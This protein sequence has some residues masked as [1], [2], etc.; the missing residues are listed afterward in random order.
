[1]T[2]RANRTP[3]TEL[4]EAMTASL[5]AAHW[6]VTLVGRLG[7]QEAPAVHDP[8]ETR[9]SHAEFALRQRV[10]WALGQMAQQLA[11]PARLRSQRQPDGIPNA[12]LTQH[13]LLMDG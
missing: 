5:D 10:T 4:N 8:F 6:A 7:A 9:R 2:R 3:L 1:M 11:R 13:G 12:G